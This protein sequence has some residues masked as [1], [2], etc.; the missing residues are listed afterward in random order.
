MSPV[1]V[2]HLVMAV[3]KQSF[4]FYLCFLTLGQINPIQ[5]HLYWLLE[6]HVCGE[7]TCRDFVI[8]V[9]AK[10]TGIFEGLRC[11]LLES[12]VRTNTT[13]VEREQIV[14][15]T[16]ILLIELS[17]DFTASGFMTL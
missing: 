4:M 8:L 11:L 7:I 9:S 6:S 10:H 12:S 17:F 3:S 13:I 16:F 15:K 2:K 1:S 5:T 14:K